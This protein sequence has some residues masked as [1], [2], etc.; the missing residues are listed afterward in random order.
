MRLLFQGDSITDAGRDRSDIHNLGRG[1]ARF[2]AEM[3][4]E[5]FPDKEWEFVNL[6]ISGNRTK[7]LLARCQTDFVDIQPDILSI[8]IGIND[9]WRAF[10]SNDPTTPE[11]FEENYRKVLEN[12]KKHTNAKIIMLE[13][14][15]LH[16]S[17]DKDNWRGDLNAK[18]DVVRR[19]AREF[20]D[21]YIPLDGLFAAA[22]VEKEPAHWAP[23]GVHPSEAGAKLIADAYVEAVKKIL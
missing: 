2:A 11:Q 8:L 9:T 4:R 6:G 14:F 22:S 23:D 5:A 19:L 1:Y 18:I 10:D 13:P 3:L 15:L 21:V 17:P 7:D 16:N 20:A 12:V